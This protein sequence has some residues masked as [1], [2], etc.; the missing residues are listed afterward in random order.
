MS[1]KVRVL[2]VCAYYPFPRHK[3]GANNV[4][5]NLIETNSF[6]SADILSL[7]LPVD[8]AFSSSEIEF[9]AKFLKVSNSAKRS[10]YADVV[11]W[12]KS[13]LPYCIFIYNQKFKEIAV[14]IE[15]LSCEYD[16]IHFSMPYLL[17]VIDLLPSEI[18]D[19]IICS[20]IDTISLF[21]RRRMLAERNVFTRLIY[22]IDHRRSKRFEF[23]YYRKVRGLIVASDV[24]RQEMSSIGIE[25][26]LDPI[27]NGVDCNY[28]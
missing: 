13:G 24:D 6:Y 12:L 1:S 2:L 22:S 14:R 10:K 8:E 28:F 5:L 4:H 25:A 26:L 20:P 27:P 21:T 17:P 19:K 9:S 11:A 18:H 3:Y 7:Y 23:L 16:I 15:T